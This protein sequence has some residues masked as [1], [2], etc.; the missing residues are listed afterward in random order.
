MKDLRQGLARAP[1]LA[2]ALALDLGREDPR[3]NRPMAPEISR[4]MEHLGE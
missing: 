1:D 3:P 4:T 2:L